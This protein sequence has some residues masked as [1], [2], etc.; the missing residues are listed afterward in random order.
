MSALRLYKQ[1]DKAALLSQSAALDADPANQTDPAQGS[2][3]RLTPAARKKSSA[4]AQAIAWHMEDERK[5]AGRPVPVAGYSGRL[6]NR[7]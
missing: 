3:H 7:R 1:F 6:T 5:A 2:I 4:L